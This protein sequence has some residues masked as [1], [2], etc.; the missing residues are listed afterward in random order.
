MNYMFKD[1]P[2]LKSVIMVSYKDACVTSMI[3]TF[4]NCKSLNDITINGFNT[5]EL[6]SMHNFLYKSKPKII[7]LF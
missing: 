2:T 6:V 4:E 3:S 1:V 7:N 5:D